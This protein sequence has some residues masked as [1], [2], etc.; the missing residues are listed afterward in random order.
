MAKREYIQVRLIDV[1]QEEDMKK[2]IMAIVASLSLLAISPSLF[3]SG[4]AEEPV[5]S[6]KPVVAVSILPQAY[7]LDRIA[8]ELVDSVVL[9]GPGQDP[10][11]YEPT[12]RQMASLANAKAWILSGTDFENSLKPKIASLYPN[13]SLVDGT[14][15]MHFRTLAEGHDHEDEGEEAHEEEAEGIQIDRH[16]WLGHENALVMADHMRDTVISLLPAERS[17]IE[18][19]HD[20]LV[21]EIDDTFAELEEKLAPLAGRIAMVYHPAFGYFFDD[22]GIVQK[23]VE[24]GGKEP[25]AKALSALIAE[26]KE[27]QVAV[28]FVQSQFPV[29]AADTV[30][31][32]VGAKVVSLDPL[33][34]DWLD[35]IR[36]M[37]D[38]LLSAAGG[39]R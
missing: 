38:A 24:T 28:I 29:E 35:N 17:T 9:V 26:A 4:R 15:G 22:F 3:A 32:A 33:A 31:E 6:E 30:A 23:A 8:G 10:H 20:R 5:V 16:T 21:E 2:K 25:T 19:N 36:T 18:Q 1:S 37:G 13:L 11:S 27:E 12:P 14:D 39:D 34:Y 7:F